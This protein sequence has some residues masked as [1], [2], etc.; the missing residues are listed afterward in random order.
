[1]PHITLFSNVSQSEGGER[2]KKTCHALPSK[3][4][5][6]DIFCLCLCKSPPTRALTFKI[7]GKAEKWQ[8]NGPLCSSAL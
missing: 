1:M 8:I 6:N 3:K 2:T 7:F 4:N 5:K